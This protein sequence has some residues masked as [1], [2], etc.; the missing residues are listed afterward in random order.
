MNSNPDIFD[1][2]EDLLFQLYTQEFVLSKETSEQL[3][4][5]EINVAFHIS[6]LIGVI[7]YWIKQDFSYSASFMCEQVIANTTISPTHVTTKKRD[8]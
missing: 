5:Y 1:R 7:K 8:P 3:I 4:H 2:I 6:A